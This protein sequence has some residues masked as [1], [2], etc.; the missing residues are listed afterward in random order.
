MLDG[1]ERRFADRADVSWNAPAGGFFVVVSVP[2]EVDDALLEYSARQHGVL[3]TP[4]TYFCDGAGGDRQLR[5][6][7]SALDRL[8]AL[9]DDT[10]PG[11]RAHAADYRIDV[12]RAQ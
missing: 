1:L 4:M 9:I 5:L 3:W 12:S 2:F 10:P 11:R 8:R 6:S 7:R